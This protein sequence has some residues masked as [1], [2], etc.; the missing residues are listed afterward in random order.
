MPALSLSR[1][2]HVVALALPTMTLTS[3]SDSASIF[4]DGKL[5]P[6][7]YKIQNIQTDTYLDVEVPSRDVCC[8]PA[9]DLGEGRGLVR[10]YPP[11][12]VHISDN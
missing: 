5:K 8:R 10:L 6:G 11:S 12:A 1:V 4:K 7:I 9:S 2:P 3:T